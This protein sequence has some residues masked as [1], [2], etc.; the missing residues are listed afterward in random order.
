MT[1]GQVSRNANAVYSRP[2]GH[3]VSALRYEARDC[4]PTQDAEA[5]ESA[6]A[7][8]E[9]LNE[10]ATIRLTTLY[11]SHPSFLDHETPYGHPERADRLRAV[12]H[13]LSD[14]AFQMLARDQ[15]PKA[16]LETIAL[17]HPEDYIDTIRKTA[18]SEGTV[19]VDADTC[20]SP[21]S[22]EASLRGVGA[23]VYAVDQVMT[24]KAANAFCAT[25]PPG[26]HAERGRAMGFCLFSNA[27]I[28]AMHARAE[29]GA[30]RLAVV[31]FDVHHGNGTQDIF[32]HDAD[33]FYGSSHE[34][35]LFPGTG[36]AN[37][38]G[39][40]NIINAPLHAGDGSDA[41]RAAWD[42]RILPALDAHS[43]DL[44]IISAGFDAHFRD[45]LANIQLTHQDFAWITQ[46]LMDVADK[47]C[48]GRMVSI[49]EGGYDLQGLAA[50]AAAHVSTLM[51]V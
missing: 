34:M 44:I 47:H 23:A 10:K 29:H 33:L 36:A 18:P 30:E 13:M 7:E 26:H 11:I 24:G 46:R 15:A 3:T 25:R 16:E 43:P 1:I 41:F 21:G 14:E 42:E 4:R 31:D 49:L 45:P 27:A 8:S 2:A 28:A 20:M 38:T 40:G 6:R 37:E 39:K 48:E 19:H 50:S 35:P 22:W 32:W 17:A 9:T 12:E 51:R 5:F